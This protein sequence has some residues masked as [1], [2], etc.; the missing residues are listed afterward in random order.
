MTTAEIIEAL[1]E[2]RA[3]TLD[4][5]RDL[6]DEQLIGPRLPIVNPLRWEIG[7]IAWFQEFW[8]LRH[9]AD[10]SPILKHGDELYDSA[11]VAHDTR[12]DLPPLERDETIAY[13]GRV[14][15]GVIEQAG[16]ASH[17][18]TDAEGYDQEYFL[19]LVLLHEQM[20]D[21]AIT[22]T[23]QTLSY[24]APKIATVSSVQ[25]ADQNAPLAQTVDYLTRDAEIP[26]GKFT[27]GNIADQVFVFDNE[28]LAHEVEI[29]PYAIS[30]TTVSNGEFRTFVEDDGYSRS[31]LWSAEG[32]Q[33]RTAASAEHP[34]YWRREGNGR[35]LRRNFDEWIALDERLPVIHVNWHE[36]NAYCRWAG[37]RLPTEAEWETAASVASSTKGRSLTEHKR[38]YPWGDD[39]PRSERANLDWRALGCVPVDALPAGD[40]AFGCRQMIG[41]VWEW[42]VSDFKPYP[43]FVAG[44]Y[45]E[46]SEPWFGNHKVL[47]GGCWA[48]RSHLIHN[49]YR[50]FYT[51]DRRDVWAGFRTC[52]VQT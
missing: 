31:E 32:W 21:E 26:G 9:L 35:W 23:R 43:G 40:N 50:N 41:N 13:M 8:V 14:L 33:W 42:T 1:R 38:R 39:S 11:R 34:V 19:N 37:R 25:F 52:A 20:H 48:T 16:N 18:L 10:H 45:K 47:R 27:L 36:A 17:K 5:V 4:L 24:P 2:A 46:Y 6:S 44:P 51:P 3:R 30:K 15:E 29:E 28:Q 12:W 49:Y 22:Y 7:H